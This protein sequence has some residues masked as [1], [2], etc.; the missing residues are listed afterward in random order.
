MNDRMLIYMAVISG[1]CAVFF[2]IYG[3]VKRGIRKKIKFF[4][5]VMEVHINDKNNIPGIIAAT[6]KKDKEVTTFEVAQSEKLHNLFYYQSQVSYWLSVI[7]TVVGFL[8]VVLNIR[9]VEMLYQKYAASYIICQAISLLFF[10]QSNRAQNKMMECFKKLGEEKDKADARLIVETY[11]DGPFKD[12][13]RFQIIGSS[14][15]KVAI[16]AEVIK[17]ATDAAM[18]NSPHKPPIIPNEVNPLKNDSTINSKPSPD[19]SPQRSDE[20]GL[21]EKG[22]I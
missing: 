20:A 1:S 12:L 13:A 11:N 8:I 14:Y 6:P 15:N 3:A 18:K 16:D 7:F 5:L 9:N 22:P 10:S 4:D 21:E 17:N 19:A 2:T